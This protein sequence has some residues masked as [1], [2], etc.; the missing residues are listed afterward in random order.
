VLGWNGNGQLGDSTNTG[1]NVPVGV[2]WFQ[3]SL[4]LANLNRAMC[5]EPSSRT[6]GSATRRIV[7]PSEALSKDQDPVP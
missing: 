3:S 1:S 5:M 2:V 4:A 7:S 6:R